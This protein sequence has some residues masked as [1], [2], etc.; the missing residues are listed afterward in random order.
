MGNASVTNCLVESNYLEWHLARAVAVNITTLA[1]SFQG[2]LMTPSGQDLVLYISEKPAKPQPE[3]PS[4]EK[5]LFLY[6]S[7]NSTS[8]PRGEGQAIGPSGF[9]GR[10]DNRVP[11]LSRWSS[12]L[13]HALSALQTEVC[14]FKRDRFLFTVVVLSL[15]RHKH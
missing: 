10:D 6:R 7:A 14:I 13:Y 12:L 5:S 11:T 15:S 1:E 9:W 3:M 8:E 2:V 4:Q